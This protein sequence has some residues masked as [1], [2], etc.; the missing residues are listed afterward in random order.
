VALASRAFFVQDPR[1][2]HFSDSFKQELADA[3]SIVDLVS[4]YVKLNRKGTDYWGCCPFHNEKSP[5]F[6]VS[7]VRKAYKCFGCGKG[8]DAYR[9]IME[10]EG[11]GFVEAVSE[12]AERAGIPLPQEDLDPQ[13][14]ARAHRRDAL[15][16]A[17]ESACRYYESVLWSPEGAHGQA[18]LTR[19]GVDEELARTFRL[20]V[21]PDAW[22]GLIGALRNLGIDPGIA[23][24]AGLVLQRRQGPG[25]YDRFRNR[26]MFPIS[27]PGGKVVA[28][29][30]R[31]LGDDDAKYINSPESPVYSKSGTLYGLHQGRAAIHKADQVLVVEGYFDVL[32]LARAGIAWAVAPCGTAL[33]DRQLSSMRRH[34]RNIVLLFDAD[35]AGQ[36]AAWKALTMG[37]QQGLWPSFLTVPDG[38]DPDDFVREHGGDAMR[39]LLTQTRPL[40]DAFLDHRLAGLLGNPF[41]RDKGLSEVAPLLRDL[42]PTPRRHYIALVAGHLDLDTRIVDDAV[43]TAK[44]PTRGPTP[45]HDPPPL[46]QTAPGTIRSTLIERELLKLLVQDLNN[47]A[48]AVDEMGAT[49]WLWSPAVQ[50]VAGRLL[51][52]WRE[53]RLPTAMEVLPPEVDDPEVVEEV[54]AALADESRWYTPEVLEKATQEC[55]IRLRVSWLEE[56]L[57][58]VN[59]EIA[60]GQRNATPDHGLMAEL[61]RESV[62][63]NQERDALRSHLGSVL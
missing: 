45:R 6:K 11:L 24:E 40:L 37:L 52:C 41:E 12:L 39:E 42:A 32:G 3:T 10:L 22:D 51:R 60:A 17:N 34:T 61:L 46:A 48:Q 20:G 29:G 2:P 31:A 1:V 5:S 8:G 62:A 50:L 13:E 36:R 43:R 9:F 53:G 55:L 25:Y 58:R 28:F 14:K 19:R 21:S 49:S 63:L 33:T 54:S 16:H 4:R 44:S 56:R 47:V 38:K 18:E 7:E 57:G 26:L 23:E 27:T 59:R 30:G 35:E 15:H